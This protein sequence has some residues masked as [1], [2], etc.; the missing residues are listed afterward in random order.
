ME[1]LEV[2]CRDAGESERIVVVELSV[3][4]AAPITMLDQMQSQMESHDTR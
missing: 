1:R 2:T 3:R 4:K